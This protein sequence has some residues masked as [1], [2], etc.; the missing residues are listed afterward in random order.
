[1]SCFKSRSGNDAIVAS[2]D[3]IKKG[4]YVPQAHS[5]LNWFKSNITNSRISRLFIGW[6]S[7]I[8]QK[9]RKWFYS[10]I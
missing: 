6:R 9:K 3:Y 5:R 2:T 1:M 7:V 8:T 4:T 10:F